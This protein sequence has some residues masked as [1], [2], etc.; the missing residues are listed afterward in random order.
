MRRQP[1]SKSKNDDANELDGDKKNE[2]KVHG[3]IGL[4]ILQNPFLAL[5]M[6]N[7]YRWLGCV[8]SLLLIP[9]S[10]SNLNY[11]DTTK[12][13]HPRY[14][15]FIL[16]E[17]YDSTS[18]SRVSRLDRN[19][20]LYPS[21]RLIVIPRKQQSRFKSIRDDSD[22]YKNG[23]A[24]DF[25]S[26]DCRSQYDWQKS[27]FPTC[28]T[29]HEMDLLNVREGSLSRSRT[30]RILGNGYWRDVWLW[31]G[32]VLK[33]LRYQHHFEERNFDR[34][35]RDALAMDRLTKSKLVVNIYGYCGNSGAYEYAEGGSMAEEIWPK[36]KRHE[37]QEQQDD[38]TASSSNISGR[39]GM[40]DL[41][42]LHIAA[43]AAMGIADMHNADKEGIPSMI[44]TDIS[45]SQ[46]VRVGNVYQLN[47][48]NR[49]RFVRWNVTANQT[50]TH[51]VGKNPGKNRSPEEYY[52]HPQS[53]KVD[54]YSFGN[55]LYM[56]MTSLWPFLDLTD[57]EAQDEVKK[58]IRPEFPEDVWNS[59]SS[60]I[61]DLKE[62]MFRCHE[63]DP[64]KRPTA[65]EVETLLLQSLG[66]HDPTALKS[67][68]TTRRNSFR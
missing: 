34:H 3:R 42:R 11:R 64:K 58:G 61:Q 36:P 20:E 38:E 45:P 44:H 39:K 50:C 47:D 41:R 62:V 51:F 60:I 9:L 14:V 29:I 33:T 57:E 30:T 5:T 1:R 52:N 7:T 67:W 26:E 53:E 23:K 19:M 59:S 25:E 54:V 46:F 37:P 17:G 65:R 6:L 40:K 8:M 28:N 27:S 31:Y 13:H 22:E 10:M 4:L 55:I 43:Q 21:K 16:K 49:V 15:R 2:R 68:G 18:R 56:L 12:M 35:R 66:K 48:F 32:V 24:D 63:Q